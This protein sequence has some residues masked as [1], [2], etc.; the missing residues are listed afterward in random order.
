MKVKIYSTSNCPFCL[1]AKKFFNENKIEYQ[2]VDVSNDRE[3]ANEMIKK[4]GQT[5]VPV[6]EIGRKVIVGFNLP[7]IKKALRK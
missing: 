3:A 4:S 1:L 5:G 2:E 6:I 7:A